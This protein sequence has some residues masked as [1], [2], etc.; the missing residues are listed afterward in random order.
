M[1]K[2]TCLF[3]AFVL[4]FMMIHI[5]DV[6]SQV[7]IGNGTVVGQRLP[8]NA[9]FG[10]S[11]SQV[12]YLAS[13]IGASGDI[14]AISWSFN[15]TSLTNSNDWTI[16]L[17]HTTKTEF[18]SNSDWIPIG[19]LTQVYSGEF[20]SPTG[21]GWITIPIS[22]FPYDGTSNLVIAVDENKPLYNASADDFHCTAVSGNRGILYFSDQTNP[23]PASPPDANVRR[24][25]IANVI[26]GGIQQDCP[27]VINLTATNITINSALLGWTPGGDENLWNI[28]YGL[29][30]FELGQGTLITD[31]ADNP[32][33]LSGL[34]SATTYDFYVQAN[35]GGG[36]LSIWMG[37]ASFLTECET[38][39]LPYFQ[40]FTGVAVNTIPVCW[41]RTHN[42]WSVQSSSS[43]GGTSPEIRLY[44]APSFT[45]LSMLQSP[46]FNT[47][48]KTVLLL[49]FKH[50]LSHYATPYTV[51]IKT[52]SDG[53]TWNT[54]WE[55]SPLANIA[56]ETK[57]VIINNS[58][59]GSP[60]FQFAF[61][62]DGNIY[63]INNWNIDDVTLFA[64]EYGTLSGYVTEVT[65]GVIEGARVFSG[66]YE[67][68]TD[69]T[70][71]YEIADMIVGVYDVTCEADGYVSVTEVDVEIFANQ[72]TELDFQ[73][74]IPN[75]SVDPQSISVSLESGST[76]SEILTISNAGGTAP[77]TWSAK[78]NILS[79]RQSSLPILTQQ[80][81]KV[82]GADEVNPNPSGVKPDYTD[83]LFDLLASFPVADVGGTYSFVCDGDFLYTGRWNANGYDKYSLEGEFLEHFEIPGA[84]NTRDLTYDGQYFYGSPN[85]ATIYQM[86]FENKTL[87]STITA[88]GNTIR[89]ISYD[90]DND[91]FWV[92][93]NNFNGPFKLI[94]RTGETLQTLATTVT[95]ISGI[96]YDNVSEDGPFLWAYTPAS[97][98]QHKLVKVDLT[99]GAALLTFD[100]LPYGIFGAGTVSGGL[101]ITDA[102]V[103]GKW[104]FI[105]CS[106]N[107][108]LF[109]VELA[110]STPPWI[111]IAPK[112]GVVEPGS[113]DQIDVSFNAT[114]LEGGIYLAN[115]NITHNGQ[116]VS[117][118]V[119]TV[120][121]ELSVTG[122]TPPQQVTLVSPENNATLVPLQP[123]FTWIT[124]TP[125]LNRLVI[126]TGAPPFIITVYTSPW[127][128]GESF[129]LASTGFSLDKKKDYYWQVNTKDSVGS[130]NSSIWKFQTIG[131]GTFQGLITDAYSGQPLEGVEV[132][133]EPGNYVVFTDNTGNYTIE[134]V[135]EGDYT[136]TANKDG[137]NTAT[138][139]GSIT[140]NVTTFV[141][142]ELG[143][144]LPPPINLQ[145]EIENINDVHLTWVEP[146]AGFEPTWL[147]YT[148]VVNTFV[149]MNSAVEFDVAM[150]FT[151]DMLT[152]FAGGSVTKV[153]FA[154]HEPLSVCSYTIKIWQGEN[155]P[156]L[157]YSQ[158]VSEVT[159]DTWNEVMLDTPVPFDNTMELWIGYGVNTTTGWPAGCDAG[160]MVAGFGNMMFFNGQWQ[161]LY[162]LAPTLP[163]NWSIQAFVE[164]AKGTMTLA[165]VVEAPVT[166]NFGGTLTLSHNSLPEPVISDPTA[167]RS[168]SVLLG[169]NV[170]RDNTLLALVT[171][172]EYYDLGLAAG[173]YS[174]KVTAVYDQGESEPAGPVS[175]TIIG[176]GVLTV[177]P[178]SLDETHSD[179]S[180]V[181]TKTL[182]VS[183]TGSGPIEFDVAVDILGKGNRASGLCIDNLYSTGC[184]AYDDGLVSW[185]LANVYQDIPC[186]DAGDW[187]HDYTD[188]VHELELGETY[189]LTV[190]TT[191]TNTYLA[192]WIDFNDDLLLTPDELLADFLCATGGFHTLDITIPADAPGGN[193]VLRFRTNW[194]NVATDP[195]ATYN[196]GNAADFMATMGPPWISVEP[197]AGVLYAE[198]SMDLVVTFTSANI[199]YGVHNADILFTSNNPFV[200]QPE[201]TVPA[202]L[203]LLDLRGTF[204]GQVL[205]VLGNPLAGVT[206]TADEYRTL[207]TMTDEQGEYVL[208]VA[209]GEYT[210]TASKVGYISETSMPLTIAT[211]DLILQDF[212][213]EYAA[214]VMI[215][216]E[217]DFFG[218]EV[219]WEGNPIIDMKGR[220]ADISLSNM[221]EKSNASI[222]EEILLH[223]PTSVVP[224][225]IAGRA[226]G[227]DC[228]DPIIVGELPYTDVNT[229]CGRGNTYSTTCLGSYD[230]GE[231][232]VYQLTL[233]E[234][235]VVTLNLTTTTTW[236][237]M[238]ITQ[239][240]PIGENCVD[241]VTGSSGNK[242]LTVT[243]T[244]G[245]YFIMMDTWP[246]PACINE[247]TLEITAED[248]CS[249]ECPAG[250]IPESELCGE[251][252]NGGCN[253]TP[254]AFESIAIGD[255][256]CGTAWADDGSRDTDWYELIITE[257]QILTWTVTAEFPVYA[258]II[259]GNNGCD[260]LEIISV[261]QADPCVPA[262][263]TATVIPGTYWLWVGNQTFDG[264]PCGAFNNYVAELTAEETFITYYNLY[265]DDEMINTLYK[266]YYYDE[267]VEQGET[268]CYSV[269][270]VLFPEVV[271]G[272][273][274]I[275]FAEVPIQPI[276]SVNPEALIEFLEVGEIAGQILSVHN[277]SVGDL[278]FA[279]S[280]IFGKNAV[281]VSGS[282][283]TYPQS[284]GTQEAADVAT[285]VGSNNIGGYSVPIAGTKD[286]LF[287][288]G[289][290]E[291]GQCAT[292]LAPESAIGQPANTYGF[293]MNKGFG[294]S[295]AEDFTVPAGMMWGIESFEFFGYQTES[296]TTSTFTGV[297]V[298]IWDGNPMEEGSS[299]IWG[300]NATNLMT[301]TEFTGIYRVSATCETTRPIMRIVAG[302]PGLEL[303]EGTYWVEFSTTGSLASGPW[304]ILVSL[305]GS[306]PVGNALHYTD[307]WSQLESPTGSGNYV[308]L[309]FLVNGTS[310]IPW[311]TIDP[312]LG[313]VSGVSQFDINVTFDATNLEDGIY[314][315][316]I[317]I[318][319]NDPVTP[320][321]NVPVTL[322]VGEHP[323]QDIL[324]PLGWSGW[325]A[326]INPMGTSFENV[327]ASVVND[328]VIT[329]HFTEMFWPQYGINTMGNFT[330]DHGYI[331]KM[332]ASAT[333]SI[334]GMMAVPTIILNAGWNLFPI[335]VD[336]NLDAAEVF[337]GITGF[338]IGYEVAGNGIYYPA[339]SIATLTTL[340][341]G[342]A[343][344]VKVS[345]ATTYTFPEC[346]KGAKASY[347]APLRHTNTTPWNEPTYTG[348]SHIVVFNADASVSFAK[349]D[350]I[351]AFTN[352]GACAGLTLCDGKAVSLALF[353]DD[354]TT[355]VKDG[356][357]QGESLTFKLY[358]QSNDTEYILVVSYSSQAPNYDGLFEANGLSVINNVTMYAT[359]IG[360]QD[361]TSLTVYP[362]PSQGLFNVSV[363][364]HSQD[365]N[366][367]VTD[368]KG[369][370]VME[371]RLA[372]SHQIDLRTQP[373]GIYFI[374]F[375]GDNV[376]RVE[377]LIVR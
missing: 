233:T 260:G 246:S 301:L 213:L 50:Y 354:I 70:G 28:E 268:Y 244:P 126:T 142:F 222:Q 63:N 181:T 68:F 135:F 249:V 195:C 83:E 223:G 20:T 367:V 100:L 281:K 368:A 319:S 183:N 31:I 350:M 310:G 113:S 263:A 134:D 234:A 42:N 10:Y 132:T 66:S 294:Y 283:I 191:Y 208:K 112:Q 196:Y 128:I 290:F 77:L 226:V 207:S 240:C 278:N 124:A 80:Q 16:Y 273:S 235:K 377:K 121:V 78:V 87:V 313:S 241:Y 214:P 129:D 197:S 280:I 224:K 33:L 355:S 98:G 333:L 34:T 164:A 320:Q 237:G 184:F 206:I 162:Q 352:D 302:T 18:D 152:G 102:V 140:H 94:S 202:Q 57:E 161:T 81:P 247:F 276:I 36:E 173:T 4:S 211:G 370:Y 109:V 209:P 212:E 374:K 157:I 366:W 116:E 269:E 153:K 288:N 277:S 228:N 96:A 369:R 158:A 309:P 13:E 118:G 39:E 375:T 337:G 329:Q 326:Y 272:M 179:P 227:D 187:Y 200:T 335:L 271:S 51:G 104:T 2:V 242:T 55:V 298:R 143:Q 86:D 76:T 353:A 331:S 65:R 199:D 75:I 3:V 324:I 85:S 239:E 373:K 308:G 363:D 136:L 291:T 27:S 125:A 29:K 67:A 138:A 287:N 154:P 155:P 340:V 92:T 171:D 286:L 274:N 115:I 360:S 359:G 255:V 82:I 251:D 21:P 312:E 175:V 54:V 59:V 97:A 177:T 250:A 356:F 328:M 79:D 279:A 74:G 300:D 267:D 262:V 236:T 146:G 131:A 190:E 14:N 349:G 119:I 225:A 322:F 258:F 139:N 358:R 53:I 217:A 193:H 221:A 108:V 107:D 295:V 305:P 151:P 144:F 35:C 12:I 22:D 26:L 253:A 43:A 292:T 210:L 52:S 123:T 317:L 297:F 229:T 284:L 130:F 216:V 73:L 344:W 215:S 5:N 120:P 185:E 266:N 137:Y 84:G 40:D 47:V 141:N 166:S 17:G 23:D 248:P 61:F 341:S 188:I 93:S 45:D 198:E 150:R 318:N 7:M 348:S 259:D 252:L 165:P 174:Y 220:F 95:G 357:V 218:I 44:W 147:Y 346:V 15:G 205:D 231:D 145:A 103:E 106:Q 289:P 163:Y 327:V 148:T 32:Y 91:A 203:T 275:L 362:N 323:S 342:K 186:E 58:D 90:S 159:V 25:Y 169:Y 245:T 265:R 99:T 311:L 110:D 133:V 72:V 101:E 264:N 316:S 201:V 204:Y 30:G 168:T 307:S 282:D 62:F 361:L 41:T 64:P 314:Y 172:T 88:T 238:L 336:C 149:G 117:K 261:G 351:G 24:E 105:G 232:I 230:G 71:Y 46:V 182:T 270:Q 293:N 304:V 343:Y 321:F 178:D 56:A 189:Q 60:T 192:I 37:P 299:V 372:D 69:A 256:I 19:E 315:A 122:V 49:E 325:S 167:T 9:F 257:P 339:G 219:E 376:L 338:I 345:G 194:N 371:G 11:Y 170:Y 296:S 332:S 334:E 156:N 243:L 160:P 176:Y 127:F 111:T 254:V 365:V 1:R 347:I 330:S 364:N 180:Q 285:E 8:I 38:M 89:A 48:G 303:E 114:D 6:R 306:T